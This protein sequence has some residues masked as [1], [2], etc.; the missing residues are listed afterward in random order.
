MREPRKNHLIQG[1]LA[2]ATFHPDIVT[3]KPS[4][5]YKGIEDNGHASWIKTLGM[6]SATKFSRPKNDLPTSS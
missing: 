2:L 5:V 6:A 3:Y 1:N 4:G